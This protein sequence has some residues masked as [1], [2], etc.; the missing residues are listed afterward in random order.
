MLR[1][2]E[3]GLRP[4]IRFERHTAFIGIYQTE[5]KWWLFTM[6]SSSIAR[7]WSYN[8]KLG[9]AVIITRVI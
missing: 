4:A 3:G 5:S 8:P 1:D 2:E 6:T 9:T 7:V